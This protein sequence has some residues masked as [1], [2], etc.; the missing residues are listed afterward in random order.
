[1]A[2]AR[3]YPE[4]AFE[5]VV[6]NADG[7]GNERPIGPRRPGPPDGA[8]IPAAWTFTPDGSALIVRFGTDDEGEVSL[9][10]LDGSPGTELG[11]G[12]FEFVDVQRL[13]R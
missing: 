13:A 1:M 5:I 7:S 3:I 6:A 4:G 11:S 12:A 9:L 2:Y 10:P 8:E